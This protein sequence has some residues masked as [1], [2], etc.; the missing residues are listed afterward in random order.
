VSVQTQPTGQTCSV[1]NASGTIGAG[2]VTNANVS[3]STNTY[4]IGGTISGL[5]GTV[6]LKLDGTTPTSTQTQSFSANGSF[7]FTTPLQSGSGWT[8]SV[9]VQPVGQ[10]CAVAGGSGASLSANVTTVVVTCTT[11]TFTL[12]YTAGAN[13]T[14][15]GTSPQTVNYGGSGSLVTAVPNTGYHFVQWSDG[16]LTAA[17]TDTNVQA[18]ISVTATFAIDT[19]TLTYTAGANG[20]IS[21]TSPQTANYG[22][23]GSLVTA[24][25]NTGYHFVQWSDG[26]MT[27]ARTDTNVQ[28]DITVQ[29]QFAIDQFTVTFK[30][31]DGSILSS[32]TVN[33]GSAATAPSSPTRTGYTFTGWDVPFSN[34]TTDLTVTAQYTINQYTVTFKDWDGST[35]SSQSVNHGGAATAPSNPTR[36]GYTFTGWDVPFSNITTDLTVTA[37]YTIN[38]F[39]LTYAAGTGGSINGNSSQ[40]VDYQGNGTAV[41]AVPD[42]GYHFVQWSDG[43]TDNP[44]T[45]ANVTADV[46]VTA[47]FAANVLAFTVQPADVAQGNTLGTVEVTEQDGS[48]NTI[49]DTATVG[50]TLVTACGTLDLGSVQMVDGVATLNSS[51]RFYTLHS[52]YQITA[53]VTNPNPTP[54]VAVLSAMFDATASAELVF[55]DSFESCR[56]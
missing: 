24:V 2:N 47:Q 53:T 56:P 26:V 5:T 49:V 51:Q 3:C 7:T 31:W 39:T 30:D 15:S 21:G 27:A 23:N 4:T 33:Y 19:F 54:M 1:T 45:D 9:A 50:L 29:A 52:G 36:T 14:I 28:A 38:Q 6:Q 48:G 41:G 12:T 22:G 25:P 46:D 32:Q 55:S 42:A 13:G 8:V 17:R 37:Q 16:V 34:I 18:N 11:N 20:T 43:I 44:R 35:L 10:T 40:T